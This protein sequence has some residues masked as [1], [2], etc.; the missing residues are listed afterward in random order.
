MLT[1][2]GTELIGHGETTSPFDVRSPHAAS[3]RQPCAFGRAGRPTPQRSWAQ[4]TATQLS[5]GE[6]V[7]VYPYPDGRE[8]GLGQTPRSFPRSLDRTLESARFEAPSYVPA[9]QVDNSSWPVIN[10]RDDNRSVYAGGTRHVKTYRLVV[11]AE[12]SIHFVPLT[13]V[14]D[15]E[16]LS[17]NFGTSIEQTQKPSQ[18]TSRAVG[19]QLKS[20][21]RLDVEHITSNFGFKM[22]RCNTNF[23]GEDV[24]SRTWPFKPPIP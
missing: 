6:S 2:S 10:R 11:D 9:L 23:R 4:G 13:I 8:D 17:G 7:I 15:V 21:S 18:R 19:D 24:E 20:D 16:G 1:A 3:P 14:G 22:Y 12:D 5:E